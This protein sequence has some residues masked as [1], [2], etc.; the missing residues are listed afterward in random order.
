MRWPSTQALLLVLLGAAIVTACDR[1]DPATPPRSV[2]TVEEDAIAPVPAA[3][4]VAP[5]A[6][7]PPPPPDNA[8]LALLTPDQT[9]ELQTLAV[10]IVVPATIPPGFVLAEVTTN[11]GPAG[12][13]EKG[14]R[15]LYRGPGD[16]CFVVE[17]TSGG[18]GGLPATAYRVPI[19]PPFFPDADYGL[20]YGPYQDPA[21]RSQFPEPELASDWL[22][23]DQGAYRLA[24]AAYINS[25]LS[26]S[27]PCQDIDPETAITLIESMTLLTAEIIGD[28]AVDPKQGP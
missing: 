25:T 20:N 3:A 10:P 23:G 16:R 26:P 2:P 28:D 11:L 27:P 12:P 7:S 5:T 24:G 1:P 14:Y 17:Y 19:N 6:P 15:L 9:A 22:V 13:G 4:D 8:F 18:V 21:L